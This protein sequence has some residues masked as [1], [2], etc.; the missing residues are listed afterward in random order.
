[1]TN[2]TNVEKIWCF[3]WKLTA[4]SI[5]HRGTNILYT[6]VSLCHWP[7][8]EKK[9]IESPLK[10]ITVTQVRLYWVSWT[11][12]NGF[13]FILIQSTHTDS[14]A[15][16]PKSLGCL[17]GRCRLHDKNMGTFTLAWLGTVALV[18]FCLH[19]KSYNETVS[20]RWSGTISLL[21]ILKKILST[22]FYRYCCCSICREICLNFDVAK[23]CASSRRSIITLSFDLLAFLLI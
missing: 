14:L 9:C 2:K 4:V 5:L 6:V 10:S 16:M 22:M 7:N 17:S 3:F 20:T 19:W 21:I 12:T 23:C 11:Q 8:K 1:M 13:I 15:A 18:Q